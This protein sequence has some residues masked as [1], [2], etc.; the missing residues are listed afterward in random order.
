MRA[1]SGDGIIRLGRPDQV[2]EINRLINTLHSLT[3][4]SRNRYN[5]NSNSASLY[6]AFI[7]TPLAVIL[8]SLVV[9][10]QILTQPDLPIP[11]LPALKDGLTLQLDPGEGE[12]DW[13]TLRVYTRS[14]G[15]LLDQILPFIQDSSNQDRLAV[16]SMIRSIRLFVGKIKKVFAEVVQGYGDDYGFLKGWWDDGEMKACAGEIGRWCDLFDV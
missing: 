15:N 1:S 8:E 7:L 13:K 4:P 2:L 14:L 3:P 11:D 6:P 5:P 12:I 16:E 9:E 10:R